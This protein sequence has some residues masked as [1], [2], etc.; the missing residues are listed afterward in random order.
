M[1]TGVDG[2][3]SRSTL[4]ESALRHDRVIV[5]GSLV[6]V[7]GV[8]WWWILAMS[9]DMYGPMT[10]ASAWAMTTTWDTRHGALL[11]AMWAVM[12]TAMMLP[13]GVPMLMLY[14]AVLR[15]SDEW[16]V[17]RRTYALAG[18]YLLMWLGFSIAAA[19]AQLVL[20]GRAAVSPMMTLTDTRVGGVVLILAALYQFSPLKRACLDVCR[21]PVR[22]LTTHWRPGA[23]GAFTMG[24]RHGLFCLGCC[25]ALMLLLFV[26]GVMNAWV[27]AG[28]TLFV[29]IEKVTPVGPAARFAGGGV[30]AAIGTWLLVRP[31]VF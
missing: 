16:A 31:L 29:L 1:V 3:D 13:S 28:L 20:N 8:S 26:G 10:G 2:A 6:L 24:L 25:W 4:L 18:G 27:V 5:I 12:M 30:L 19:M 21:S 7:T 15:R 17:A 14:T 23:W 22:L 11:M 9:V